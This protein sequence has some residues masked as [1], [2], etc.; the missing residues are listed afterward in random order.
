MSQNCA[1]T[2]AGLTPLQHLA[3]QVAEPFDTDTYRTPPELARGIQRYLGRRFVWDAACTDANAIAIPLWR[4]DGFT[5]GDSLSA[6]WDVQGDI[7]C[8]P[9]Y[10][11][12]DPWFAA[13]L[14]S[15]APTTILSLSPNGEGRFGDILPRVHEILITGWIDDKGK[16]RSGRVAF[17]GKDGPEKQFNRGSS[18]F[19]VNMHGA[20]QRSTVTLRELLD[21]GAQPA[22]LISPAPVGVH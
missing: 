5:P 4:N 22:Q 16:S 19:L 13:A 7:F 17:I 12:V 21:L 1:I 8:N 20:G 10:S 14:N 3:Q 11:K 2:E 9:P 15:R 18:L 6:P